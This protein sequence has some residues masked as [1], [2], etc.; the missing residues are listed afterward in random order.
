M[1][2]PGLSKEVVEA[3]LSTKIVDG[4][5]I[6]LKTTIRKTN[7]HSASETIARAK[8]WPDEGDEVFIVAASFCPYKAEE[9]LS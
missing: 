9:S 5:E 7:T 4:V 8:R 1:C 3:T 2:Q 6:R